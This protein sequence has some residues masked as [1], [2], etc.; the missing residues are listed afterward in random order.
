MRKFSI[1]QLL[2]RRITPVD[3]GTLGR[4]FG[5]SKQALPHGE[6]VMQAGDDCE[7]QRRVQES[8]A[9]DPNPTGPVQLE[10]HHKENCG[11][12]SKGIDL[13]ENAGTKI[14]QACNGV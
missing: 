12:L 4:R 2:T 3:S 1:K 6:H 7:R 14:A 8:S 10:Q 5:M 13:P 9:R 11:D